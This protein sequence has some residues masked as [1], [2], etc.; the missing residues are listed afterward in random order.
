MHHETWWTI[1]TDPNHLIAESIVGFVE[2]II[3]LVIGYYL[4]RNKIWNKIHKQF[5]KEHQ[6]EH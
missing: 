4:G 2:E 5:D 1:L 3:V 6:I